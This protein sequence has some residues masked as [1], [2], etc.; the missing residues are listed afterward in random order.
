[1][2][3]GSRLHMPLTHDLKTKLLGAIEADKLIFLCGAGLS[4]PDP[5]FLPTAARVA[6]ICYDRWLPSEPALDA[7]FEWDVDKL[8]GHFYGRGDFD[9]FLKLV[10]WNDLA[11]VPNKGHAAVSDMLL[12]RAAR[13]ALSANFDTM[14]ERWAYDRKASLRG[15]LNGQ[16]AANFA[17]AYSPLVKFHG[18]M[19]RDPEKTVW[20]KGQLIE[21]TIEQRVESC[22]DWMNLHLPGK[23]LIVVGFWTDWG[24][25]N[26]VLADAFT[27]TNALS[28]TVIDP[29]PDAV[30]QAKAPDLWAKLHALSATFVHLTESGHDILHDLRLAYSLKWAKQFYSRGKPMADGAG[31][32][33]VP[34]PDALSVEDLYDL[35]RDAEGVPYTKA[36]TKKSAPNSCGEAA[37]AHIK[38]LDAGA[39]QDGA[40]LNIGGKS[41]RVVS[42]SGTTVSTIRQ[43]HKEPSTLRQPDIVI[44]AGAKDFGVPATIVP[45]GKGASVVAPASGGTAKWLTFEQ[46]MVDLGL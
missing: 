2:Q 21:P 37:F 32:A 34:N 39:T 38:L 30:L 44:C 8:A 26:S 33:L 13:G 25:L 41:V 46:S 16:E 28:V 17:A 7:A 29:E 18:C 15:A 14:I 5:S 12:A 43:G 27:Q 24:Y 3:T 20:T 11:G 1:M 35:R 22:S 4:M 45:T 6:K 23:H 36:A 9:V 42:A 40:W 31:I 19:D 10:P